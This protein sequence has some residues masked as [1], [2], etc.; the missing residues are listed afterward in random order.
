MEDFYIYILQVNIGLIVFYVF[1]RMLFV[2]DTFLKLRRFLLALAILV[3][4]LY[5]LVSLVEWL[6]HKEVLQVVITNYPELFVGGSEVSIEEMETPLFTINDVLFLIWLAVSVVL[7][8]RLFTQFY[9]V[10]RLRARGIKRTVA[11]TD[12]FVLEDNAVPFSFFGWIFI[13]SGDYEEEQLKQI[14]IHEKAHANQWHSLDVLAGEILGVLFWFN[15]AVWLLR[16]EV[17]QNLEFL[18]DRD[19]IVSG[20]DRKNYQYHLLRLSYEPAAA[21]IINNFNVSQLKKR[22]VMMNREKKSKLGLAKYALLFPVIGLLVLCGNIRTVAEVT[23]GAVAGNENR[24]TPIEVLSSKADTALVFDIVEVA[25]QFPGGIDALQA[26]IKKNLI[27]PAE[28]MEKG[29]RGTV[30]LSFIVDQTGKVVHPVILYSPSPLLGD[31]V[32]R[33]V[34]L[35]PTWT[36]GVQRGQKV[37]VNFRMPIHFGESPKP[38]KTYIHTITYENDTT[39]LSPSEL[40]DSLYTALVATFNLEKDI[41]IVDDK[42]VENKKDIPTSLGKVKGVTTMKSKESVDSYRKR[43][44]K[45]GDVVFIIETKQK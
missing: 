31:E 7:L 43:Y 36:P 44:N 19:V 12:V 24:M 2:R 39:T 40:T 21:K 27:Y 9:S 14:I 18:A 32:I 5:P 34:K 3:S 29:I 33:L 41:I 6:E 8:F 16:F 42:L 22:I 23:R 38:K 35:M 13:H 4:F 1:Y 26:F 25:P 17:R 37:K 11:G 20:Y 30:H 28:A 10:C 15:P 45:S